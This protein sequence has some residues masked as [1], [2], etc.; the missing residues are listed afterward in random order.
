M[1]RRMNSPNSLSRHSLPSLRPSGADP[2]VCKSVRR[3]HVIPHALY[4]AL[5]G[6]R[7]LRSFDDTTGKRSPILPAHRLS[8]GWCSL[9]RRGQTVIR[10]VPIHVPDPAG[11]ASRVARSWPGSWW[12]PTYA[13][14]RAFRLRGR[15]RT[16][17]F[18][19]SVRREPAGPGPLSG[20]IAVDQGR[21]GMRPV[22]DSRR[23]C[24]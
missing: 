2:A 23:M 21:P 8:P 15:G 3:C 19:R 1:P 16:G 4:V 17:R 14:C 12:P 9:G 18:E 6:K 7:R 11:A 24:I 20:A 5:C 22:R 13:G 10:P